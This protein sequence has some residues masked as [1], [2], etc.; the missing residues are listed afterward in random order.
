[1]TST[2]LAALIRCGDWAAKG[3]T[4]AID[5]WYSEGEKF[6]DPRHEIWVA[7]VKEGKAK[8]KSLLKQGKH[9][10][11]MY[12]RTDNIDHNRQYFFEKGKIVF[13]KDNYDN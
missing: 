11:V 2:S 4:M 9:G 5:V 8:M 13:I 6:R 1:M 12:V 3:I 7:S 10:I